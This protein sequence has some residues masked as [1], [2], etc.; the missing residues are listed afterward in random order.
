MDTHEQLPSLEKREQAPQNVETAEINKGDIKEA[1]HELT[2]MEGG[3]EVFGDMSSLGDL[4][5]IG[6]STATHLLAIC[7]AMW[8]K[9]Q[10]ADKASA[11]RFLSAFRRWSSN[12][13]QTGVQV[14]EM[15]L[16]QFRSDHPY[17]YAHNQI[18]DADKLR[19]TI[20]MTLGLTEHLGEA[21]K[22][23]YEIALRAAVWAHI[24]EGE[25]LPEVSDIKNI[26][27]STIALWH[28]GLQ[29]YQSQQKSVEAAYQAIL[30]EL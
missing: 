29:E 24:E 18:S 3:S 20:I 14:A 1:L 6:S 26:F 9:K 25:M 12:H 27:R 16:R 11:S 17:E 13:G 21:D 22:D 7:A 28:K 10:G 23:R 15:M 4:G 5:G 19:D 30:R 2:S 8:A